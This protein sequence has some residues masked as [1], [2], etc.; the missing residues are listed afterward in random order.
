M[1]SPPLF[2]RE[3][4]KHE[5]FRIAPFAIDDRLD[6]FFPQGSTQWDAFGHFS[7][8]DGRFYNGRTA[9]EVFAGALGVDH[10]A[11]R[12]IVGRGVLLDVAGYL[13]ARGTPIDQDT[14]F[15]CNAE[16][17]EAT[18]R[19][20]GT[21]LRSGDILCVRL[22]WVGWYLSL[23][24]DAREDLARRS[25]ELFGLALPGLAP[26]G[27]VTEFLWDSGVA[28]L[29]SDVPGIDPG[30]ATQDSFDS[31][32]SIHA[33]AMVKLGIPLGEFFVL[34]ELAADCREDG[35]YEFFLTS[36]PMTL[37]A[38]IGSPPNVLAIK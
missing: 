24:E 9:D 15:E 34:D 38:G 7:L 25:A 4:I 16:M 6:S 17:M 30:R 28:A 23:E 35:R 19:E 33:L 37:S 10:W 1:P 29:A 2:G 32:E 14:S 18:A 31:E 21:T 20:Q 26:P 27:E 3:P 5:V 36:S 12:G 11:V 8:L 13:E 22:G